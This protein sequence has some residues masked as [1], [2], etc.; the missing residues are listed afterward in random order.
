MTRL[1]RW[2]GTMRPKS[3]HFQPSQDSI[4]VLD[5][6]ISGTYATLSPFSTLG[7]VPFH[8]PGEWLESMLTHLAV[9]LLTA[10]LRR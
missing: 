2:S 9:A 4:F 5:L 7:G 1:V 8:R 10:P 6:V 3:R